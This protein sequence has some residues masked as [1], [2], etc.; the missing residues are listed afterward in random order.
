MR[1]NEAAQLYTEDFC[2]KEGIFYF[3]IREARADGTKC[4]KHLKTKQSKRQIPLHEEL[5]R[6]GFVEFVQAR[7]NDPAHPRLFP[8]LPY[9][10]TGYFSN[11]FSKWFR[12]FKNVCPW[13]RLQS[14]LTSP[15][16]GKCV[17][18]LPETS[19]IQAP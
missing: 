9:G 12:R 10:S 11:P 16:D 15:A 19:P 7:K 6:M 13:L 18:L 17:V 3:D 14:N 8:D 4:E 5:I 2:E 1:C